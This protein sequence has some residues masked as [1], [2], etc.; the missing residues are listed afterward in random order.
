[1]MMLMQIIAPM[2]YFSD[3]ELGIVGEDDNDDEDEEV[4]ILM[5]KMTNKDPQKVDE[6]VAHDDDDDG[7]HCP[8]Y[9]H[10]PPTGL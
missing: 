10:Q 4:V 1:M 2:R 9:A 3:F 6:D 7:S 5:M 8:T